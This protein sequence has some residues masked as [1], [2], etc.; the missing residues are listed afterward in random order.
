MVCISVNLKKRIIIWYRKPRKVRNWR[1]R[2]IANWLY[3]SPNLFG[4]IGKRCRRGTTYNRKLDRL[5][6]QRL[7][8][9][10]HNKDCAFFE[11]KING[12]YFAL[13]RP[14]SGEIGGNYIRVAESTDG[15]HWGNHQCLIKTRPGQWDSKRIG[16]GA[17]PRKTDQGWL[18]IYHC[19][20]QEN[21]YWLGAFL[22]DLKDPSM[23]LGR[24]ATLS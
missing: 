7:V 19:V 23:V 20:N 21:Q 22:T 14:R 18:E 6:A 2:G 12:K 8:F 4:G 24:R 9:P 10:L 17:A 15:E 5:W 16:A 13:H 3:F 1:L 11:G